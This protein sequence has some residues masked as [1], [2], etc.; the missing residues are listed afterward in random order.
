MVMYTFNQAGRGCQAA[1]YWSS[2][3]ALTGKAC[4]A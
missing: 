2:W 1:L 4:R 3:S